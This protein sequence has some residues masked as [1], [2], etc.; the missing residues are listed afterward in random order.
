MKPHKC[1][2]KDFKV[3][4]VDESSMLIT[5]QCKKYGATKTQRPQFVC[6]V[7]GAADHDHPFGMRS[8]ASGGT[9]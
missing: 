1:K 3:V 9:W 4:A 8:S 7:P 2:N 5:R 6:E